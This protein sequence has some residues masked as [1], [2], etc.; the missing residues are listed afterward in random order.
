M[1][2]IEQ[3]ER[4]FP[5]G[6][7]SGGSAAANHGAFLLDAAALSEYRAGSMG[8]R[9]QL[10]AISPG[11]RIFELF[12]SPAQWRE[13]EPGAKDPPSEPSMSG[14]FAAY[15]GKVTTVLA[16]SLGSELYGSERGHIELVSGLLKRGVLFHTFVI[17]GENPF[18]KALTEAGSGLIDIPSFLTPSPDVSVN[19]WAPGEVLIDLIRP[20]NSAKPDVLLAHSV[21]ARITPRGPEAIDR[22]LVW[23]FHEFGDRDHHFRFFPSR[24]S[25]TRAVLEVTALKIANSQSVAEHLFLDRTDIE[26]AGYPAARSTE[27]N[28]SQFESQFKQ[29]T[30]RVGVVGRLE[31]QKGQELVVNALR[32]LL[33]EGLDIELHF[34]GT[35]IAKNVARLKLHVSRLQLSE[36]VFFHGFV[37]DIDAIYSQ[38]DALVVGS[39]AEAY[40][41]VPQEAGVRGIPTFFREGGYPG[42]KLMERFEEI[43]FSFSDQKDLEKGLTALVAARSGQ[44]RLE[45]SIKE[46]WEESVSQNAY[47]DNWHRRLQA[48]ATLLEFS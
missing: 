26:I 25:F 8:A 33:D 5:R 30:V 12:D 32:G 37:A 40:G 38:L 28:H 23:W 43:E 47:F 6:G 20:L 41:R 42:Q 17:A 34:F 36:R 48:V 21:I 15:P 44:T 9:D 46:F 2:L 45:S 13:F 11:I 1:A 24:D 14:V 27:T 29:D 3:L 4:Y 18:K 7:L 16:E 35:G 22:P 19:L 10:R 39:T 31:P